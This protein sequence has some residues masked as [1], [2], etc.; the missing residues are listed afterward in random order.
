MDP[1]K[2]TAARDMWRWLQGRGDYAEGLTLFYRHSADSMRKRYWQAREQQPGEGNYRQLTQDL[3]DLLNSA[4]Y[5]RAKLQVQQEP[6]AEPTKPKSTAKRVRRKQKPDPE[7]ETQPVKLLQGR[8]TFHD[9]IRRLASNRAKLSNQL[10]DPGDDEAK[11]QANCL[12]LDQIA[13]ITDSIADLSKAGRM[14]PKAVAEA[15]ADPVVLGTVRTITYR[16]SH[17]ESMTVEELSEIRSR[18]VEVLRKSEKRS[19]DMKSKEATRRRNAEKVA[20]LRE[21]IKALGVLMESKKWS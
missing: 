19:K 4:P 12:L 17:L 6:Q 21:E 1:K 7:P 16:R 11:R 9:Q 3:K 20:Q 5:W 15:Q 2:L 13:A 18:I 14:D 8:G 10:V